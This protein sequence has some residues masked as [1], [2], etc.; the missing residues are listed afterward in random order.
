MALRARSLG[1]AI[2]RLASSL[3]PAPCRSGY[4]RAASP[5]G[6]LDAL[7]LGV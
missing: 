7:C 1:D 4:S 2:A 3:H 5:T 6:S